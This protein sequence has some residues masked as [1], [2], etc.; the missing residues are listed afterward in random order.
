MTLKN[1]LLTNLRTPKRW[2]DKCLKIPVSENPSTSNMVNGAKH[3]WRLPHS[4]FI[5]F[6]DYCQR[7]W[8]RESLFYWYDKSWDCLLT[9]WLPM[10]SNLFLTTLIEMKLSKKQK[11]FS[12]FFGAFLKS[13]LNLEHFVKKIW[14]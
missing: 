3:H 12:E 8:V 9:H 13:R 6:I 1:F 5:I 2:W 7:N 4:T 10:T 14:P 11:T